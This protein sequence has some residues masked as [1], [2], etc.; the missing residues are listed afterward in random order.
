MLPAPGGLEQLDP[1]QFSTWN[2]T[3]ANSSPKSSRA[4]LLSRSK[5]VWGRGYLSSL[6]HIPFLARF[7]ISYLPSECRVG[8][9]PFGHLIA[10]FQEFSPFV[11]LLNLMNWGSNYCS[12]PF[13]E[14]A[15]SHLPSLAGQWWVRGHAC[16]FL[17]IASH[18][19]KNKAVS[20]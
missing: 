18:S 19:V 5:H 4:S 8:R 17:H 11:Y 2:R 16:P 14:T 1:S 9:V 3:E 13:L 20:N 15:C 12:G 6:L 7:L 10:G